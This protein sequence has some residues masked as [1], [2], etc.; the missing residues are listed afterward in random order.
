MI[1]ALKAAM[2]CTNASWPEEIFRVFLLRG[3]SL[4]RGSPLKPP[5]L[6]KNL[7]VDILAAY[8]SDSI[9]KSGQIGGSPIM[10]NTEVTM[11]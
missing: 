10:D 4:E 11:V 2:R 7:A 9:D 3:F 1:L 8:V 6:R 5:S